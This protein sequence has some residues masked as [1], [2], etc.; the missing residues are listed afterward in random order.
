MKKLKQVV[1]KIQASAYNL[2]CLFVLLNIALSLLIFYD[3]VCI[4]IHFFLGYSYNSIF[5]ILLQAMPFL[6]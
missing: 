4:K 3:V 6:P 5:I 2:V 1:Q